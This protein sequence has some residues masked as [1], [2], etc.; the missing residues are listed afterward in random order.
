MVKTGYYQYVATAAP[1]TEKSRSFW[2]YLSLALGG[3]FAHS[4]ASGLGS[5]DIGAAQESSEMHR[6]EL[7]ASL[8]ERNLKFD[9]G[10]IDRLIA[11]GLMDPL[12]EEEP[13]EPV[14]YT[15]SYD[16]FEN[17]ALDYF[18]AKDAGDEQGMADALAA[19]DAA[20]AARLA[21]TASGTSRGY[22]DGTS[23][24]YD[25][26]FD[27]DSYWEGIR[28]TLDQR[29]AA[30]TS[31]AD[32]LQPGDEGYLPPP[33]RAIHPAL[34]QNYDPNRADNRFTDPGSGRP[35][36]GGGGSGRARY[37]APDR[38]LV[39]EFVGDKMIVLT[40]KRQPELQKIVDAYMSAD[41]KAYEG[42][43]IDPKA[44]VMEKIRDLSEYKRIHK[45]R[46][47]ATDEN[48][49]VNQRQQ[50]LQQLGVTSAAAGAR[51]IDLAAV[52]TNL[53]DIDAGKFQ[54]GRGRKDITLMNRLEK[55]AQ[56]VG[57]T[58]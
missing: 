46:G 14:A 39:E 43:S 24:G 22:D 6:E 25:D 11:A 35:P 40:G 57:G 47:E 34:I 56:Q 28:K 10:G 3:G 15:F 49:W 51:G 55:V 9:A 2:D 29:K 44:E 54:L 4:D 42:K 20:A 30:M 5:L 27:V 13:E 17:N 50:R 52:G 32:G 33:I 18:M 12:P 19:G 58:L 31:A 41:R 37:V 36:S 45:L 23:R 21:T 38:R 7:D 1:A 8:E 48:T 53:N 26:G 16:R